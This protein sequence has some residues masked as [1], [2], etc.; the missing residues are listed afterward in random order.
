MGHHQVNQVYA[1]LKEQKKK[2]NN[3]FENNDGKLA[4]S[5]EENEQPDL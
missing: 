5:V 4:K 3:I 2:Y 1:L